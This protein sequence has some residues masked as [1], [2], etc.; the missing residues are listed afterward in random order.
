MARTKES[1]DGSRLSLGAQKAAAT[2]TARL[3][4]RY[5]LQETTEPLKSLA[6]RAVFMLAGVTVLAIG[7][8]VCLFALLRV[9]QSETGRTFAGGWNFAPYLLTA[10]AAVLVIGVSA[11][12]GLRA[13]SKRPQ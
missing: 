6:K 10:A 4:W 5:V 12:I 1:S 11:A 13:R 3:V 2:E 8:V 9:L 7:F